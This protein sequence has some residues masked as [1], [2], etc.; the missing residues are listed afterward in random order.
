MVKHKPTLQGLLVK[1]FTL[2]FEPFGAWQLQWTA[3]QEL[4]DAGAVLLELLGLLQR[5]IRFYGQLCKKPDGKLEGP[6]GAVH[7]E[8]LGKQ[9]AEWPEQFEASESSKPCES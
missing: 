4:S 2:V 3:M 7:V 9:L 8:K 1:L 6:V 5:Q